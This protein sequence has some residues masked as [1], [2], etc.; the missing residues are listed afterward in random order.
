MLTSDEIFTKEEQLC[1]Y[2]NI[3][4]SLMQK[5]RKNDVNIKRMG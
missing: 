4:K 5:W 2:H 1:Y 3:I